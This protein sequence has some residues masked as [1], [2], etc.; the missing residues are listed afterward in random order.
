MSRRLQSKQI[1]QFVDDP[2]QFYKW[3][4]ENP[5][6][7]SLSHYTAV[8]V[9]IYYDITREDVKKLS[10]YFNG[11]LDLNFIRNF[12][13]RYDGQDPLVVEKVV[14]LLKE[15]GNTEDKE[16]I[17]FWSDPEPHEI[18]NLTQIL[19]HLTIS[20]NVLQEWII[21]YMG[22]DFSYGC[23]CFLG[24]FRGKYEFDEDF[25][26]ECILAGVKAEN[27]L[28][29]NVLSSYLPETFHTKIKWNDLTN[30]Y[31]LPTLRYMQR[32]IENKYPLLL[33]FVDFTITNPK[34]PTENWYWPSIG[35]VYS[36]DGEG[37]YG[38]YDYIDYKYVPTITD[39][40][41]YKDIKTLKDVKENL[42][43]LEAKLDSPTSCRYEFGGNNFFADQQWC[44]VAAVDDTGR[45]YDDKRSTPDKMCYMA[46]SIPEFL[47][48]IQL[49][50][51]I[52]WEEYRDT[53]GTYPQKTKYKQDIAV[54]IKR[55]YK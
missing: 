5:Q 50:N 38:T 41:I 35:G 21:Y 4:A 20:K 43:M 46:K 27:M 3:L 16:D 13:C 22:C 31:I 2:Q 29:L 19:P 34:K 33:K 17:L 49:E 24:Y 14:G 47:M 9:L 39:Y 37:G 6:S 55:I 1:N 10:E 52:S 51:E 11:P 25:L 40:G 15:F 30:T 53:G 12:I 18:Y 42:E 23:E 28:T 26:K 7:S 44:F 32:F 45:V 48:R 54:A 36:P 8:D